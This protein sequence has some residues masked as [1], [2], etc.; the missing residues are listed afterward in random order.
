M[1]SAYRIVVLAQVLG[2]GVRIERLND[3]HALLVQL[4]D[5]LVNRS[6][7][8]VIVGIAE[9]MAPVAKVGRYH[10]QIGGVHQIRGQQAAVLRL[11][12]GIERTHQN[13]HNGELILVAAAVLLL[14]KTPRAYI[15]IHLLLHHFGNVG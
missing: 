13:R 4:L 14:S 11:L 5:G 2:E 1:A 8:A 12:F 3:V 10:K 9:A 6:A 7:G 15:Q